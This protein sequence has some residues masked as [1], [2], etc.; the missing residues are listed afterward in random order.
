M[1]DLLSYHWILGELNGNNK[2]KHQRIKDFINIYQKEF[3]NE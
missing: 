3:N 1:K 2:L